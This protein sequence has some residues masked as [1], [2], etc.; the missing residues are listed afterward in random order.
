MTVT[1]TKD[2]TLHSAITYLSLKREVEGKDIQEY[3]SGKKFNNGIIE[4]RVRDYLKDIKIY[5]EQYHLTQYGKSVQETGKVKTKEEG[6]Y[7]IWYTENDSFFGNKIFYFTRITPQPPNQNNKIQLLS[8]I[9]NYGEEHFHLPLSYPKLNEFF[10]FELSLQQKGFNGEKKNE[11]TINL[12]WKW[13]ELEDS[14]YTFD[15]QINTHKINFQYPVPSDKDLKQFILKILPEWDSTTNRYKI[16]FDKIKDDQSS[17]DLFECQF[18]NLWK[19]FKVNIDKLPIEPYNIEEAR[20]WRNTILDKELQKEYFHPADF[21]DTVRGVNEKEGFA[22][23]KDSLDIPEA[24]EYLDTELEKS[25]K[26]DRNAAF[27]HIRA[28]L[29]LNPGIPVHFSD[30]FELHKGE[31]G[32]FQKI[33]ENMGVNTAEKIFYY[34][35]YVINKQQQQK[36]EAFLDAFA[37]NTKY[38][39]TDTTKQSENTLAK[40]TEI[41]Q[42]DLTEIFKSGK[43]QHDRYLIIAI[44]DELRVWNI[45]NS[46]DYIQFAGEN[47]SIDTEGEIVQSVIFNKV[48]QEMLHK[49]LRSFIQQELKN[50]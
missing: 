4:K 36:T 1:L 2:I 43:A 11:S 22:A 42:K 28:P 14:A 48:N 10:R 23:Y 21:K 46:M 38:L 8:I 18:N 5:D 3:V 7:Q 37:C 34:D 25:K 17:I 24:E 9:F 6:K 49:E 27:W 30:K 45:S 13:N 15:G 12:V 33:V 35:K 40:N 41:I 16:T 44:A 31:V 32:S 29:D 47:I 39:I 50:G 19:Y 20:L 26:S